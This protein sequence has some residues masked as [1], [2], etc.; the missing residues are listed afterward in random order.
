MKT[1]GASNTIAIRIDSVIPK[2]TTSDHETIP[3]R[4]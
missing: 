4:N 3:T 1:I 2:M